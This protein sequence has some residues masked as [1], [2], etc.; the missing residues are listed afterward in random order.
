MLLWLSLSAVVLQGGCFRTWGDHRSDDEEPEDECCC[1]DYADYDWYD[2]EWSGD[3]GSG[4][5]EDAGGDIA[6]RS[7]QRDEREKINLKLET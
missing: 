2:D 3:E 7:D 1:G 6:L 4:V 5:D